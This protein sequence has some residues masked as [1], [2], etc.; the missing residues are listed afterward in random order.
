[1]GCT[2]ARTRQLQLCEPH[3]HQRQHTHTHENKNER[4]RSEGKH[5][6]KGVKTNR[7]RAPW[8]RERA[9]M[10][11]ATHAAA[12][13]VLQPRH[14]GEA[15]RVQPANS[16]PNI[17]R[18]LR[19]KDGADDA[20]R[21]TPQRRPRR[22]TK[23]AQCLANP[24][25]APCATREGAVMEPLP[26]L[27]RRRTRQLACLGG[28]AVAALRRTSSRQSWSRGCGRSGSCGSHH[29][30]CAAARRPTSRSRSG[31]ARPTRRRAS[32]SWLR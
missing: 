31:A 3:R 32:A 17:T 8:P 23:P 25:R 11:S 16:R 30:R 9:Q 21:R 28:L 5:T 4:T 10:H 13:R 27:V 19:G 12:S 18:R 26:S 15:A 24:R 14:G 22:H 20:T 29:C 6:K 1:M 7:P 2:R